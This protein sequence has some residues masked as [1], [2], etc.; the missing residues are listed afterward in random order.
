MA[1]PKDKKSDASGASP[2]PGARRG[3]G[4]RPRQ[5]FQCEVILPDG[6]IV[7]RLDGA[8]YTHVV[9]VA[10]GP[11]RWGV[12]VFCRTREVAEGQIASYRRVWPGSP[13]EVIDVHSQIV[14]TNAQRAFLLE[15]EERAVD[16]I[17]TDHL[18][19]LLRCGLLERRRVGIWWRVRRTAAGKK[20]ILG[21][22]SADSP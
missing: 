11:E 17:S 3:R 16:M 1:A 7:V 15:I 19:G 12:L 6:R 14:L 2:G 10:L 13:C 5:K 18:G 9:A 20:A 8:P 4:S 22:D 21:E